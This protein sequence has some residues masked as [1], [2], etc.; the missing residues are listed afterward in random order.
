[1]PCVAQETIQHQS[2]QPLACHGQISA[3]RLLKRNHSLSWVPQGTKI[4]NTSPTPKYT[5]RPLSAAMGSLPSLHPERGE[6]HC[7]RLAL[8]Q[9][10][11]YLWS[12]GTLNN[13]HRLLVGQQR[14]RGGSGW[15]LHRWRDSGWKQKA[16]REDQGQ[17]GMVTH[18][19]HVGEGEGKKNKII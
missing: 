6:H 4:P 17:R 19:T 16:R 12:W 1:M 10:I 2:T 7:L 5:G 9:E 14:R 8:N 13:S 3:H 11:R 18:T 15:A